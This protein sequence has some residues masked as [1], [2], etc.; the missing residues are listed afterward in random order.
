VQELADTHAGKRA[1]AVLIANGCHAIASDPRLPFKGVLRPGLNL[2]GTG[3]SHTQGGG[4]I[5]EFI[6]RHLG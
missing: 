2:I 3:V 5:G 1:T 6:R 4:P